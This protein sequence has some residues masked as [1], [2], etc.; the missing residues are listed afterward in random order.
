MSRPPDRSQ[1]KEIFRRFEFRGLLG[2]IDTLDDALP[3]AERPKAESQAVAWREGELPIVRGQVGLAA[4][5]RPHR[6]SPRA[7]EVVVAPAPSYK[8]LQ[9]VGASLAVHDAK[10]AARRRRPTTRSS[11]HT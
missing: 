5:V 10:A 9:G 7:S 3:A 1:L 6:R 2:R 11:P 8:L 4:G